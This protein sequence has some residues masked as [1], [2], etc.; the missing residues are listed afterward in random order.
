M[1]LKYTN[2]LNLFGSFSRLCS[3]RS[4]SNVIHPCLTFILY[5][6]KHFLKYSY[7]LNLFK[8][9][10]VPI[11]FYC[12]SEYWVLLGALKSRSFFVLANPKLLFNSHTLLLVFGNDWSEY[13]WPY[14]PLYYIIWS[15]WNFIPIF[16]IFLVSFWILYQLPYL[17][18]Q[19]WGSGADS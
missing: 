18:Y 10:F 9:F 16:W 19:L 5:Y 14:Q 6:M 13:A 11:S 2:F 3:A 12:L 7:F 15:S 17:D 1:K 8:S 4:T